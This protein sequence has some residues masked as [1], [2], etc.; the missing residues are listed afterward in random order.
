MDKKSYLNL[1]RQ[2]NFVPRASAILKHLA[3]DLVIFAAV[4]SLLG[5]NTFW[6][7]VAVQPLLACL[8]FRAFSLMH[9]AVHNSV[10]RRTTL[11]N[12]LGVFYGGLCFLPFTT[13]RSMHL[14]HHAWVGNFDKD[15]VMKMVRE[16]PQK[17]G[18]H[19]RA[20]TLLW[21]SWLPYIAFLQE[22]VFWTVS[23]KLIAEKGKYKGKRLELIASVTATFVAA[24]GVLAA[25]VYF[26]SWALLL[27]SVVIYLGMVE[28][29]NLPHHLRLPRLQRDAK[30]SL[31]EQYQV[32]RTCVYADWFSRLALLNF[33]Y[34]AEHHM[35]PTLPWYELPKAY[36]L[37]KEQSPAG[38]HLCIGHEWIRE[39]RQKNLDEVFAPTEIL[40][41]VSD[42]NQEA[43]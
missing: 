9:D 31:W 34:H 21:R 25:G 42:S 15:P 1:Q 35:F 20:D 39:N 19:Q 38:Y 12:W 28:V 43:A 13:W 10:S 2:L 18:F 11:N 16:F 17:S 41:P 36:A 23:A 26:G 7:W 3:Q 4:A 33:N 6:G 27:P 30:L 5:V 8:Y 37:V 14:E 32:S 24:I 29:I 22:A 40:V